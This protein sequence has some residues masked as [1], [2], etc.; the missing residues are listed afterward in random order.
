MLFD[1]P[2]EQPR[3]MR[4]AHV[5]LGSCQRAGDGKSL[6][7][8]QAHGGAGK[9]TAYFRAE[10]GMGTGEKIPEQC[11]RN[12]LLVP[13]KANR[14]TPD[15]SVAMAEEFFS[16]SIVNSAADIECPQ[17][18]KLMVLIGGVEDEP[19]KLQDHSFVSPFGEHSSGTPNHP[20][21][22]VSE[23]VD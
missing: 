3:D 20:I 15:V 9:L 18:L 6:R 19:L 21:A 4:V 12:A 11:G 23:Q 1:C 5:V 14:P 16:Y 8:R 2:P 13:Q 10:I 7:S 22:A 17:S